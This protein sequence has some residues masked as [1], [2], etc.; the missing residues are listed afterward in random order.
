MTEPARHGSGVVSMLKE[1][2][3]PTTSAGAAPPVPPTTLAD[4]G[5]APN[6]PN[7]PQKYRNAPVLSYTA[8]EPE[9]N[10]VAYRHGTPGLGFGIP[11][12][13]PAESQ[14]ATSKDAPVVNVA[15]LPE[16]RVACNVSEPGTPGQTSGR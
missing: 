4:S 3:F 6:A 7:P 9:L 14:E 12:T 13:T 2:A 11:P 1:P 16:V 5:L 15:P 10:S 8:T